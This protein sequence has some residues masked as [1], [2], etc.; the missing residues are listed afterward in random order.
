MDI[1]AK[2]ADF[3]RE[4]IRYHGKGGSGS[5]SGA[6]SACTMLRNAL[7]HLQ[8][9]YEE[10][11]FD[12]TRI[13]FSFEYKDTYFKALVPN[14]DHCY[15]SIYVYSIIS[16]GE[17]A[18]PRMRYICNYF[19]ELPTGINVYYRYDKEE[20]KY[21][22]NLLFNIF[23]SSELSSPHKYLEGQMNALFGFSSCFLEKYAEL[24]RQAEEEIRM[25]DIE[26]ERDNNQRELYLLL[27]TEMRYG[28]EQM[29]R[30]KVSS[31]DLRLLPML[32]DL[33]D[34]NG[35]LP[36]MMMV[37]CQDSDV[38]II[39]DSEQLDGYNPMS[40]IIEGEGAEAV[41]IAEEATI[42][43]TF[44][45]SGMPVPRTAVIHVKGEF[46]NDYVIYGRISAMIVPLH[47]SEEHVCGTY[48][49]T[50]RS[51]SVIVAYDKK[52]LDQKRQE[53]CY[54]YDDAQDKMARGDT[55]SLTDE[56]R[57][58]VGIT[59]KTVGHDLY[60]G[61]KYM[62]ERRY[63][64]ATRHLINV[65]QSLGSRLEDMPDSHR[66]VFYETVFILGFC[67]DAMG[68]SQKAYFYLD[69][70]FPLNRVNYTMEYINCLVN[71]NDFRAGGLIS[72]LLDKI[73]QLEQECADNGEELD[74][75]IKGFRNFLRRRQVCVMVAKGEYER[76]TKMLNK[77]ILEPDNTEFAL[78]ELVY[79][80]KIAPSGAG[81]GGRQA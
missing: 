46:C 65:Y 56:Q 22:I 26:V 71:C 8:C 45:E 16:E 35:I 74:D 77:M 5:K 72:G 19:N 3:L 62:R 32:E 7:I 78:D 14:K 43:L 1:K 63:Y 51:K 29:G 47:A 38:E 57:M 42:T 70:L 24:R 48:V 2:I 80:E 36:S 20:N 27:E 53:F 59:N 11:E 55:E 69:A 68:C 79:I 30:H 4:L 61:Y 81:D 31:K 9:K 34:L 76:A 41:C 64:E 75:V 15:A 73:G 52:S 44:T 17:D 50:V 6:G 23:L 10:E 21:D 28:M 67:Y 54:M 18:L 60:W 39:T 37:A 40:A 25:K 13:L 66:D 12:N 33:F 49:N 58:I